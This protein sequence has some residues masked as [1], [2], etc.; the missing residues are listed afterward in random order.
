MLKLFASF[1]FLLGSNVL[2]ASDY[3]PIGEKTWLNVGTFTMMVKNKKTHAHEGP[4]AYKAKSIKKF[5]LDGPSRVL[6][7]LSPK[8]AKSC[9]E[10][11]ERLAQWV[12]GW[13][14]IN[15]SIEYEASLRKWKFFL[16]GKPPQ[17][18][19]LSCT[20]EEFT[21]F[22][23]RENCVL[24][25]NQLL[26]SVIIPGIGPMVVDILD[27]L[28]A[29]TSEQLAFTDHTPKGEGVICVNC[30]GEVFK[31]A[32]HRRTCTIPA[33]RGVYGF[34]N[35]KTETFSYYLP[36][37]DSHEGAKF[38]VL[39]SL[40]Q[41]GKS[42]DDGWTFRA[43][44][45]Y[46]DYSE[47][48]SSSECDSVAE[49]DAD[50]SPYEFYELFGTPEAIEKERNPFIYFAPG[51]K[52]Y[53]TKA[54]QIGAYRVEQGNVDKS[55]PYLLQYF[56]ATDVECRYHNWPKPG[57]GL[58]WTIYDEDGLPIYPNSCRN[59][60]LPLSC[61]R[62]N[63]KNLVI[64][65]QNNSE[66]AFYN[67]QTHDYTEAM[68]AVSQFPAV[69]VKNDAKVKIYMSYEA[70]YWAYPALEKLFDGALIQDLDLSFPADG[71]TPQFYK[72]ISQMHSLKHLKIQSSDR[73]F[74][75][76]LNYAKIDKFPQG[77]ISL[78]I[79]ET[80]LVNSP[81]YMPTYTRSFSNVVIALVVVPAPS[82]KKF[83]F[84]TIGSMHMQDVEGMLP[85][86]CN[87]CPALEE[88]DLTISFFDRRQWSDV[89][90]GIKNNGYKVHCL[91]KPGLK[92]NLR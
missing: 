69:F 22:F 38:A 59:D 66:Q 63:L 10:F 7:G 11:M 68:K 88:L 32:G 29:W 91:E 18:E 56:I 19:P 43:L 15:Y 77:L 84:R 71:W 45:V 40:K 44:K 58:R 1:I 64:E 20:L 2:L 36:T 42:S 51:G 37:P 50:I 80:K 65:H 8:N 34:E 89:K 9:D 30:Q 54:F 39:I 48:S 78:E 86:L 90:A 3:T 75:V 52:V 55:N 33:V 85:Q 53:F 21:L 26:V 74:Q 14:I 35:A 31:A 47:R 67:I 57:W 13:Q 82:L 17:Q 60:P 87:A 27:L 72:H 28:P 83:V 92:L 24:R 49:G 73:Y 4:V 79:D 25:P 62:I 61:M 6:P 76:Y 5:K 16:A 12:S 41:P 81:S 70:Q 46:D 23:D